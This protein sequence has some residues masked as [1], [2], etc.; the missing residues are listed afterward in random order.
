MKPRD[1]VRDE[2][3]A[4]WIG[5]AVLSLFA[6]TWVLRHTGRM[7]QELFAALT[8]NHFLSTFGN[9]TALEARVG[10]C[11]QSGGLPAAFALI[12]SEFLPKFLAQQRNR[13]R[14]LSVA[15]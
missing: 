14:S 2:R 10:E 6:R 3:E 12:E 5:D 15:R 1:A 13:R 7:D 8:S 11:Y 9:P 4:A